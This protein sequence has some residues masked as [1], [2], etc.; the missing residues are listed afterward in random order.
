MNSLFR[1]KVK[2]VA[3]RKVW[4]LEQAKGFIDGE[5][6][7]RRGK[8]PSK[9][10]LIGIDEYSLGFRAGY[11]ERRQPGAVHSV[12]LEGSASVAGFAESR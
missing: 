4:S 7:R 11:F 6:A 10:T 12:K 5:T 2:V 8:A 1:E 9:L 3:D